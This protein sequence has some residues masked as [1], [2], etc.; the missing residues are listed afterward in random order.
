[1]PAH[2]AMATMDFSNFYDDGNNH[3]EHPPNQYSYFQD[4]NRTIQHSHGLDHLQDHGNMQSSQLFRDNGNSMHRGVPLHQFQDFDSQQ[5]TS[6]PS[7]TSDQMSATHPQSH[8]IASSHM[9]IA[10]HQVPPH[11]RKKHEELDSACRPRLTAEQTLILEDYFAHTPRP[12][13]QQKRQ[14]AVNLGLTQEK[15]NVSSPWNP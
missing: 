15:V 9:L 12:T 7:M 4:N 5:F 11:H 6:G 2:S 3:L 13:T 1:M 8:S 10:H 14:H